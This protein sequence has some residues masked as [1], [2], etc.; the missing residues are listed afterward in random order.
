[1][2]GLSVEEMTTERERVINVSACV[3]RE[4]NNNW[5]LITDPCHALNVALSL[6]S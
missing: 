3:S 5:T 2:L 1:M 6:N 4:T